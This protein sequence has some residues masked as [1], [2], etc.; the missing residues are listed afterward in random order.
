[1][2]HGQSAPPE[3]LNFMQKFL[4][5]EGDKFKANIDGGNESINNDSIEG[6]TR[7]AYNLSPYSINV[8]A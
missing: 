3:K 8:P 4:K 6:D 5:E 1:M 2:G 7:Q